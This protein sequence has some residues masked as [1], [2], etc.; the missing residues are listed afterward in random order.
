MFEIQYYINLVD[1]A[2]FQLVLENDNS[3]AETNSGIYFLPPSDKTNKLFKSYFDDMVDDNV[4]ILKSC[5]PQLN[6]RT[7]NQNLTRN[8]CTMLNGHSMSIEMDRYIA[9]SSFCVEYRMIDINNIDTLDVY[10]I[11]YK[12]PNLNFNIYHNTRY[13]EDG[14]RKDRKNNLPTPKFI[15]NRIKME[16]SKNVVI[17]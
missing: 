14:N 9:D 2:L 7:F 13:I 8:Y 3:Y 5:H 17:T 1:K 6:W 16:I 4:I 15:N 11:S 12:I 10:D